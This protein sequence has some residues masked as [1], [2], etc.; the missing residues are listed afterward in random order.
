MYCKVYA[1]LKG[2][3]EVVFY[4][5]GYTDVCGEFWYADTNNAAVTRVEEFAILCI[6]AERGAVVLQAPVPVVH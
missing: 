1:R 6:D 4:K 5:D 2:S 3:K